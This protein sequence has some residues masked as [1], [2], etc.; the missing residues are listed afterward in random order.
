MGLTTALF[1]G[2]TG[3]KTNSTMLSVAGNNIANANTTA[4]KR[5]TVSFQ[6]Q[7]SQTLQGATAPSATLGGTNPAQ[8]GL[9]V[10]IGAITKDFTG[11][12]L[13]PTG[14]STNMALEGNGFFIVNANGE[15]RFTRAG[16]FGLDANFNLVTSSG[17]LV[18]GYGVTD[19][20]QV[21]GGALANINLPIG[22]RTLAEATGTI[23]FA[24]NLNAGGDATT[25][26]SLITSDTLYADNLAATLADDT[27]ALTSIYD[28]DGN[29]MFAAGD[30]ISITGAT[31]GGATLPDRTFEVGGANTTD[32]DDFGTTMQD[33]MD[34][35]TSVLGIDTDI[36]GGLSMAAG[37]LSIEGNG[38]TANDLDL[39]DAD[40]VVNKATSPTSPITFTKEQAAD[41]E[42]TRTTMTAFDSL[43]NEIQLDLSIVLESKSSSGTTW[44]FYAQS[45]DDTD[46]ERA[47]GTG[48]MTFGTDGKLLTITDENITIDR[49]GTGAAS[50]QGITL[51]FSDPF[52]SVSALADVTSQ[53]S[54]IKQDGSSVGTLE[55]F[56]VSEDGT[57]T[58]IFSN[59]LMRTLGQLPVATF[60]NPE[61]LEDVGG[62]LYRA[63]VNSGDANMVTATTGGAGRVIGRALEL[64]NVE[65]GDEFIHLINASTGFSASSRVLTT[66]DQLMQEL[67]SAVR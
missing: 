61:G 28:A 53:V 58:G 48:T 50:P 62:S 21:V 51:S 7:I 46:L 54:A 12:S 37:V 2:L 40:F 63:T 45:A 49:E 9:G 15:Q 30:V 31:K 56:N 16:N 24:G 19:D 44:R 5:S 22:L 39:A 60:T 14:V 55:D 43:G 32:S 67:L 13:N 29:A 20:Y 11:G 59:G 47:L 4:Y 52:G 27:T 38:G 3:L 36:S 41:G 57:I 18:Q 25:Q 42:S 33:L 17:A 6:T 26:G 8:V 66:A 65:L 64:S 1:T 23:Q 34:F 35:M 10:K